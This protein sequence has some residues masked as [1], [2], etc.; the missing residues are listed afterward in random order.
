[1][2]IIIARSTPNC[3]TSGGSI[4]TT[5]LCLPLVNAQKYIEPNST[6]VVDTIQA[7]Q[8]LAVKWY[9]V[10][11]TLSGSKDRAFE[12]IAT[13]KSGTVE[14]CTYSI[15]GDK[16]DV[17]VVVDYALGSYRLSCTSIETEGVIVYFVRSFVPPSAVSTT[18]S[19]TVTVEHISKIADGLTT[20]VIDAVRKE[21]HQAVKWHVTITTA[22]GKEYTSQ[23]FALPAVGN[24]NNYGYIG[25]ENKQLKLGVVDDAQNIN[26]IL[27]NQT[28]TDARVVLTRMPITPELPQQC[29]VHSDVLP[30][31]P[32]QSAVPAFSST[33]V[34]EQM[35]I[36]G[37]ASVRW[38]VVVRQ[39]THKRVFEVVANRD[40]LTGAN[41]VQYGMI[42]DR[43]AVDADVSLVGMSFVLTINNATADAAT[44]NIIRVP[45]AV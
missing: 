28:T 31:I 9:I 24:G 4:P 30:W 2:S 6:V 11:S 1:M 45:T 36:P 3:S 40:G 21:R 27:T 12:I 42:G 25:L 39:A 33:A 43:V 5:T 32:P 37:H 26:L 13:D 34:D 41:F 38:I 44:I 35:P 17:D 7:S 18:I 29:D 10:I 23:L 14:S 22:N 15:L 8:A 20:T 19:N 16:M